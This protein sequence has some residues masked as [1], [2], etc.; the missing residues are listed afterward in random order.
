MTTTFVDVD[1][2]EVLLEEVEHEGSLLRDYVM[3]VGYH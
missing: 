3:C 1:A 2:L